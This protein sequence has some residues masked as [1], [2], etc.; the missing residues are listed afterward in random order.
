MKTRTIVTLAL[1]VTFLAGCSALTTRK[2]MSA[3]IADARSSAD[4]TVI[5]SEYAKEAE[6]ARAKAAEHDRMGAGYVGGSYKERELL[7]QHCRS[8]AD[9]FRSQAAELDELAAQHRDAAKRAPN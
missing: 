9:R 3:Q 4:H 2:E 6:Q 8:I 7:A 1:A 5:A